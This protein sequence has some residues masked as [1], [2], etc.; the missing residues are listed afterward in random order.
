MAKVFINP[1]HC[2]GVDPGAG[3]GSYNVNEADIVRDIGALVAD[4]LSA[5]G[6]EVKVL[7]SD[8]L[9]GES[10]AYPNVCAN[11][12]NWPADIFVSL[13]CNAA[14]GQAQGTECFVFSRWS[15]S[16]KLAECIQAQLVRSL[17]TVDRGVKEGPRLSVLHNT[18]MPAVLVELAFIDNVNDCQLLMNKKR[19][20]A[21]AVARGVT[22]YL[23]E[24]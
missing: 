22:D 3:N 8:N 21:A 18:S 5:A 20:F 1:G 16:D 9:A 2:P 6:C 13:H 10:P 15:K 12:N 11:A 19:E 4:Y 17:G 23:Q 7:Q 24:A 14:S